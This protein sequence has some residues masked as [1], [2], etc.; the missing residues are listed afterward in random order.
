MFGECGTS[1]TG[2]RHNY[3]TC[4]NRKKHH[5]CDKKAVRQEDIEDLV[6][7]ATCNI[8]RDKELLDAIIENT[9]QYYLAQ[10][11]NQAELKG[12]TK[13]LN[14]TELAIKNLLRAIEAGILT[15]DTKARMD[16]LTAQKAELKAAIADLQLARGFHL[17]KSHIAY[18]LT[19]LCD[20]NYKDR[21]VQKRLI[22]TFV[23]AIFVFDDHLKITFNFSGD[24]NAVTLSTVQ[25]AESGNVFGHRALCSTSRKTQ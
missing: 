5:A 23:N 4:S 18:Y 13:Q 6:I 11:D 20:A 19:K 12:L 24:K 14:Q 9:W 8:F 22:Q 3:Y 10:S 7:K 21:D 2:V 16:E 1:R 25:D 15:E 17:Q